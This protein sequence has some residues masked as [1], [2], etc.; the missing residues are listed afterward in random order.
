MYHV[1]TC[2]FKDVKLFGNI[3]YF[4]SKGRKSNMALSMSA[5]KG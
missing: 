5:G 3:L 4:S 2:T 1:E